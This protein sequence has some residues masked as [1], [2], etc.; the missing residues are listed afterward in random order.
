M[1]DAES[2]KRRIVIDVRDTK[3]GYEDWCVKLKWSFDDTWEEL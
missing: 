3:C 2:A 1:V